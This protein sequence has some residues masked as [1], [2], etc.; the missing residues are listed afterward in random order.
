MQARQWLGAVYGETSGKAT[1]AVHLHAVGP[2]ELSKFAVLYIVEPK[3]TSLRAGR[4][5]GKAAQASSRTG[6]CTS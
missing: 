5:G 3:H 2:I 6:A 1:T 4:T